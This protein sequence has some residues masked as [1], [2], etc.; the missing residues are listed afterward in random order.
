MKSIQ[1]DSYK[2]ISVAV[3]KMQASSVKLV[4]TSL[5]LLLATYAH[6]QVSGNPTHTF[7]GYNSCPTTN[8]SRIN[9][10][11]IAHSHDDVGWLKTVDQYYYGTRKQDSSVGVQHIFDSVIPQLVMDRNKRF[12]FVEISFFAKWWVEQ[13]DRMKAVVRNLVQDGRLEFINGGWCMNDEATTSYHSIIEQ[14]T[15]GLKFLNESF[16]SCAHPKVGWQIDPFGHTNEQASLFAQ[17][18]FDGM[19]FS[20]ITEDDKIQRANK[21]S[22]DIIWHG[23]RALSGQS[24]SIFANIFRYNYDAPNGFCFDVTCLDDN[25]VD[26]KHSYEYNMDYKGQKF[27]EFI[28]NYSKIKLTNHLLIPMGGDFQFSAASQNF[29]NLDKL[30]KFVRNNAHDINIFYSTPSCY[31]YSIYQAVTSAS[32]QISLPEK[33]DD[34]M[35]YANSFTNWW[36]GYF[37]SRPSVKLVER[38]TAN[39][40]QVA[41]VISLA[42]LLKHVPHDGSVPNKWVAEVQDHEAKCLNPLWEILGDLQHHDAVTG[43]EKQHVA[44]DYVRRAYDAWTICAKFIGDLRRSKLNDHLRRSTKYEQLAESGKKFKLNSVYLDDTMLCPL[45]NISQCDAIESEVD[46]KRYLQYNLMNPSE[47][48]THQQSNYHKRTRRSPGFHGVDTPSELMTKAVLLNVYNPLA[49]PATQHDIRLPC[50]GRCDL[51]RVRVVHLSTNET[52]RLIR[53]PVPAGIIKL[54]FRDALTTY[55]I[56][57]YANIP[58]LGYTSFVLEDLNDEEIVDEEKSPVDTVATHDELHNSHPSSRSTLRSRR[59]RKRSA[60]V[61]T[62]EFVA[63]DERYE[64]LEMPYTEPVSEDDMNSRVRRETHGANSNSPSNLNHH[65]ADR[66]I[67]K[68]DLQTGMI[69]GLKRASDGSVLNIT[70]KFGY[71]FATNTRIPP[72]A[73]TFRPNTSE[74]HLLEKPIV[75]KMYK[76]K[77]GALI[78]IHQ[79]WADWLWQTIRVDARHNYIEFDYVVG[80]IP[81]GSNELGRDVVTRYITNMASDGVFLT[82]SNGRQLMLRHRMR[83]TV[84]EQTGGSF[85]PVVSTLAL[86]NSKK[87]AGRAEAVAVL[88]DRPQG[89]S[90]LNEG[91]MEFLIH[92][93]ML[94]DDYLGVNEA[95]NEPGEDGR[96]LVTRGQHR[97]YLKFQDNSGDINGDGSRAKTYRSRMFK[98]PDTPRS[99]I[100]Y[101]RD[102]AIYRAENL[103]E[104]HFTPSIKL[105]NNYLVHDSIYDDLN[106]QARRSALRPIVTFDRLRV[107]ASEFMDMLAAEGTGR[108]KTDLTLLNNSLPNNVHLLTLQPWTGSQNEILVRF[109]NLNNPLTLHPFPDYE[110]YTSLV[111][112]Y[113][114][115]SEVVEVDASETCP[116]KARSVVEFD[117]EY[118]IRKIRIVSLTEL[119]LGANARVQE[120]KRLNWTDEVSSGDTCESNSTPTSITLAPRQIRTFVAR[121]ESF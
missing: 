98:L 43:T 24:G 49:R 38:E 45:L 48:S 33:F 88:V 36:S 113:S 114:A 37:T 117:I 22:L 60:D 79:K 50:I 35:P 52:M 100:E 94:E 32:P 119:T 118:L 26:N 84:P 105:T 57:F 58:A 87:L 59:I 17:F 6:L 27:I 72:G 110:A 62:Q 93:R 54:P 25:L 83:S 92:R 71:Y 70:Q 13:D 8:S 39:L 61:D 64:Y 16:G 89:G 91:Q 41:R 3:A 53:L 75:Y 40:L 86:H 7:C 106:L 21:K 90:S 42:N 63:Q 74:P 104:P 29:R 77:D 108:I 96:G 5:L 1:F 97:L 111:N 107:S 4:S 95:L 109:E 112:S 99:N 78:E 68:F 18:G 120:D 80:P 76:R 44:N 14:M 28:R 23:D 11:I 85:Y 65:H 19:F 81:V 67:I 51:N 2:L 116:D 73:Y 30:I 34:F 9:V 115:S 15:L 46:P 56:L 121:F 69:V 103:S 12:I 102:Y 82:D 47:R 55:E 66:V 31:Q 10:H 101:E 20:R